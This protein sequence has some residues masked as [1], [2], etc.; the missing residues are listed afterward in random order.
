VGLSIPD[1][2]LTRSF[3][4]KLRKTSLEDLLA[5]CLRGW[6]RQAPFVAVLEDCH[7]IDELSRDLLG[8][9]ARAAAELPV[10]FVVAYRP[11]SE[12]GGGLGIERLPSFAEMPLDRMEPGEVG[13]IARSK[14]GQLVGAGADVSDALIELVATRSDGNPFYVE[15]LLNYIAAQGIDASDPAVLESLDLPESLNSLVLSRIDAAA[16]GPRRT[17]KVASVIGR[18]FLA[19]M[20]P[21]TYEELGTLDDVLGHLDALRTLDLIAL[22]REAELAYMFKHGVTQEVAYGSLP[23]ALRAVLHGRIGDY[24]ERTEADDLDRNVPLLAHHYYR[25]DR[26]DK[27]REYLWKAA[28]AAHAS[29]ANGAAIVFYERLVPL[30]GGS[31]G[32][33]ARL[34]LGK[35][36]ELAGDWAKAG[37]VDDV[38][39]TLAVELG[40][41]P[42]EARAFAA[43][44]EVARKQGRFDVAS[45]RLE[46]AAAIFTMLDDDIGTGQVLHLAGTVAAQRGD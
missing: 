22:D 8:V 14:M 28:E 40:D 4:A 19:P 33:R 2:D 24:I 7:W 43:L 20:L 23:F 35:A 32:V 18:T 34:A 37:E 45:S 42:A 13:L 26:E 29:Y 27:K 25:S 17:M 39:L 16:E 21:G 38:A 11:A 46:S 3:D 30:L 6:A 10:L 12:P 9:L 44:A 41:R 1:S 15:E 5:I 36:H 31:E